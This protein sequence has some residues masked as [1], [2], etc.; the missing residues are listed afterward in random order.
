M[1]AGGITVHFYYGRKHQSVMEEADAEKAVASVIDYCTEHYGPLSFAGNGL[2]QADSEPRN[3]RRATPQT[4]PAF[5]MKPILPPQAWETTARA[6]IPGEVMIHELVHQWWGLANMF[7]PAEENGLWSAEGLTVYTTYR[8]VKDLYGK[9]YAE[10]H[11]VDQW[12][13][14]VEDYYLKFLRPQSGISGSS[15][16]RTAACDFQQPLLRTAVQ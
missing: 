1:K 8:I 5:W 3:G 10:K 6:P 16:G 11:Y 2:S 14:T 12:K 15:S 7:D 9:D 13:K 4:A